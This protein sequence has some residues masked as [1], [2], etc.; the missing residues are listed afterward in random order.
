MY[1]K[2]S[3]TGRAGAKD[4][5]GLKPVEPVAWQEGV[6]LLGEDQVYVMKNGQEY[7]PAWCHIVSDKWSCAPRGLRVTLLVDVG[8]RTRCQECERLLSTVAESITKNDET[9]PGSMRQ[10]NPVI[11]LRVVGV[12]HGILFLAAGPKYQELLKQTAVEP[13]TP[14]IVDGRRHGMLLRVDASRDEP[15]L[16]LQMDPRATFRNGAYQA[17][18]RRPL[19]RSAT[20]PYAVDSVEPAPRAK[21]AARHPA[22]T[23]DMGS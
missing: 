11:P 23:D 10:T 19:Q 6:P 12:S 21:H 4:L 3:N 16:V 14:L 22:V 13:A 5:G 9:H 20:K 18:L 17:R 7:H 8:K 15:L 1:L 2:A